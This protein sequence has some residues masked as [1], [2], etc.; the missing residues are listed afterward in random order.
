MDGRG[1][2]ELKETHV[3]RNDLS[4]GSV[5]AADFS[6]TLL[7]CAQVASAPQ[8]LSTLPHPGV[9]W[10]LHSYCLRLGVQELWDSSPS[11]QVRPFGRD[12]PTDV[13]QQTFPQSSAPAVC[14]GPAPQGPSGS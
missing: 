4:G 1:G 11:H 14:K 13:L 3:Q 2:P 6:A 8:H 10:Q 5:P 12:A 9:P 7:G